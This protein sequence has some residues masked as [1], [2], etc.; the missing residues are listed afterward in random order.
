MLFFTKIYGT[1]NVEISNIVF[2]K[3]QYTIFCTI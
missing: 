1:T 2:I 3:T